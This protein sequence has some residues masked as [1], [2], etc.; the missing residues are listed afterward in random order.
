M[1]FLYQP[2]AQGALPTL[3]AATSSEAEA[4]AYYG[5]AGF[6]ELSGLPAWAGIPEQAEDRD[7]AARLWITL[8][9]LS[10]VPFGRAAA[11]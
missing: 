9:E 7:V 6:M 11:R 8:E 3:Y 1:P 10:G 4:G 2:G 5:P